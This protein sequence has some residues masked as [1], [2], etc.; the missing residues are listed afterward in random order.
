MPESIPVPL[1]SGFPDRRFLFLKL[2]HGFASVGQSP[3]MGTELQWVLGPQLVQLRGECE[4]VVTCRSLCCLGT[5]LW[6]RRWVPPGLG[7]PSSFATGCPLAS[8]HVQFCS[9]F[10]VCFTCMTVSSSLFSP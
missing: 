4:A 6:G 3:R 10:S 1:I 7:A 9:W 2:P 8:V 5:R